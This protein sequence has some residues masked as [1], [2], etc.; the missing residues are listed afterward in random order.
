M[1]AYRPEFEDALR[2]LAE[3]SAA[4]AERRLP[5]PILVGGAA[6][7]FYT[8]SA[9]N[10]GDFDL[11]SPRQSEL[12]EE[13]QKRGFVRPSGQGKSTRGWIHPA[14]GLGFEIVGSALLDGHT[15]PN[16]L[17][18]VE[19]LG[20][21]QSLAVIAVEDLIADRMGQFASGSAPEMR[22][23]ARSLLKLHPDVDLVYLDRRVR[24]ETAGLLGAQNVQD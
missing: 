16:K 5:R 9:I 7:E 19:H 20:P 22:E 15:D 12:E 13:M 24:H 2:M 21:G 11:C 6:V 17:V 23:Q 3:I 14:L 4:M 8:L 18:L 1:S 10:T